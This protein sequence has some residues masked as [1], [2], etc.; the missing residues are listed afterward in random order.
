MIWLPVAIV[1]VADVLAATD[2][3]WDS[4]VDDDDDKEFE[5]FELDESVL[6]LV[7]FP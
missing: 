5:I 2:D 6:A 3:C 7:L 4:D 1:A